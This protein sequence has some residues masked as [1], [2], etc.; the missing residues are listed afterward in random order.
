MH[1]N[2]IRLVKVN[3][4]LQLMMAEGMSQ[5]MQDEAGRNPDDSL[6]VLLLDLVWSPEAL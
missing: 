3:N 5:P 6:N 2:Q 1:C 4:Q